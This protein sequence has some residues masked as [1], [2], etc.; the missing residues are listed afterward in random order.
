MG[1]GG[2]GDA[3]F[4][5]GKNI[6]NNVVYVGQGTLHPAL[7]CDELTATEASWVSGHFPHP[8]PFRCRSKVRYRQP[9]QDCEITHIENGR[10]HVRFAIPQRA[11]TPRQSI[12]FYDGDIC[13]GGA[14]IAQ[15]GPSYY[16]QGRPLPEIVA[17]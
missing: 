7:F 10:L 17:P 3:W 5:L 15:P 14:M 13:L 9:D 8:L 1:I 2:A 12:V 6:H 16:E 11:V 4:V